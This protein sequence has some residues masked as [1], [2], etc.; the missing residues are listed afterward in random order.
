MS[1]VLRGVA[2]VS[3]LP[4]PRA[5][6]LASCGARRTQ[7][8]LSRSTA[9]VCVGRPSFGGQRTVLGGSRSGVLGASG[10]SVTALFAKAAWAACPSAVSARS[11]S[12]QA[13]RS[14]ARCPSSAA[15]SA[16]LGHSR[17]QRVLLSPASRE[18]SSR[19]SVGAGKLTVAN[20][21]QFIGCASANAAPNPSVK[22]TAPGVPWSAAYL[23]RWVLQERMQMPRNHASQVECAA[24]GCR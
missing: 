2:A 9:A 19:C 23:K 20:A 1:Q 14:T 24:R 15:L 7:S 5:V 13:P 6:G 4:L 12:V 10:A 16:S 8:V 21:S 17:A 18:T 11:R 22:R 3:R